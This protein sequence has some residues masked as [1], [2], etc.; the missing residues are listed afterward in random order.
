MPFSWIDALQRLRAI[1]Q[2]GLTYS[3]DAYDLD[4]YREITSIVES[5]LAQL[6]VA[7][8]EVIANVYALTQG[9]PTPK[10]DVRAAVFVDGP[11]TEPERSGRVLLV[12]E[13]ADGK[14]TL[15]GGWIDETDSPRQA[16]EREVREESG[17]EVKVTRLVAIKDRN[18]RG[19]ETQ[20]LGGCYK[21]FFLAELLGGTPTPSLETSEI[22]FFS[23]DELPPLSEGRSRREDILEAYRAHLDPTVPP[24]ID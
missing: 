23:P 2:T 21:L 7:P 12:R 18:R 11:L 13:T 1:A 9:Y 17:Y 19:Y 15:P 14:W 20:M 6:L 4:R 5:G 16:A 3:K 22:G 10:L 24:I 8:P